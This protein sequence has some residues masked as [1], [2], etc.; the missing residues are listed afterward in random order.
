[1]E[2]R[3]ELRAV[4]EAPGVAVDHFFKEDVELMDHLSEL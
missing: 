1:M 2:L 3:L 4:A